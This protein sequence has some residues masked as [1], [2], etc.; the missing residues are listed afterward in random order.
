MLFWLCRMHIMA[1]DQ[2]PS[3][4]PISLLLGINL[5]CRGWGCF[6]TQ[7]KSISW[8]PLPTFLK[9]NWLQL[10]VCLHLPLS[11]PLPLAICPQMIFWKEGV[12]KGSQVSVNVKARK[13]SELRHKENEGCSSSGGTR[14]IWSLA[15]KSIEAP[16]LRW[17]CQSCACQEDMPC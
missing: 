12:T 16:Q 2:P 8:S 13:C 3:T 7:F 11:L 9:M 5:A 10:F 1:A 6:C 4:L 14:I 15:P 17:G